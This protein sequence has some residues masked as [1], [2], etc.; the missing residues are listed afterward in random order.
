MQI[1]KRGKIFAMLQRKN[2]NWCDSITVLRFLFVCHH[3]DDASQTFLAQL[4]QWWFT[5][6]F[7]GSNPVL[8][9]HAECICAEV[10]RCSH[11]G[12][13]TGVNPQPRGPYWTLSSQACP[14]GQRSNASHY[15][16]PRD[17][18]DETRLF[19]TV[20]FVSAFGKEKKKI[21]PTQPPISPS[22]T[23]RYN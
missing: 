23:L 5:P 2:L 8:H 13:H 3:C 7:S 4:K 18:W 17:C 16:Y 12:M 21:Q 1:F 6:R 22:P 19:V 10:E 20:L 15:F 11:C 14:R 9:F